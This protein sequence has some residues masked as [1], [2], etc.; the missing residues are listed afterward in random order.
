MIYGILVAVL[1]CVIGYFFSVITD[2]PLGYVGPAAIL[3]GVIFM[4]IIRKKLKK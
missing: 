2:I 3:I 1:W 4:N